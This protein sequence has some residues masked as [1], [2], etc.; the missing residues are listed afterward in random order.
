MDSKRELELQFHIAAIDG[1]VDELTRCIDAGVDLE[2]VAT[3]EEIRQ[4]RAT[5][6]EQGHE[7][8]GHPRG[9]IDTIT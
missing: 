5:F 6:E 1:T 3:E 4:Y 8:Q 2:C 7:E 9:W